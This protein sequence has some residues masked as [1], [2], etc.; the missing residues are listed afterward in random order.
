MTAKAGVEVVG[1][2]EFRAALKAAEDAIPKE[3]TVALKKAGETVVLPAVRGRA[4]VRSGRLRAGYAVRA[5]GATARLVN[6]EPYGA[7]AEWGTHKKW[8]GF[9]RYGGP[10]RFGWKAI[11]ERADQL[12]EAIYTELQ[13]LITVHGWAT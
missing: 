10:G 2:R 1:L 3:L 4:A 11:E 5:A 7:G 6:R 13:E 12:E 8:K 9:M